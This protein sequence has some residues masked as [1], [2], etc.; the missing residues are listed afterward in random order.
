[1]S[2]EDASDGQ[3]TFSFDDQVDDIGKFADD[4]KR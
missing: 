2:K 4:A 3:E 1:M